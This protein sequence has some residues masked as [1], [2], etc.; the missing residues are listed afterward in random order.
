M[1]LKEGTRVQLHPATDRWMMGDRYGEVVSAYVTEHFDTST[2]KWVTDEQRY[3][4]KL[5]TSGKTIVFQAA[6]VM[7]I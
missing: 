6:D 2:K 3:R 1:L 4:V 7:A 5:D